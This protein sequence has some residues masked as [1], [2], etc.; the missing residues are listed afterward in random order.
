M[1]EPLPSPLD[2]LAPF[3]FQLAVWGCDTAGRVA[4]TTATISEHPQWRG[5]PN[6]YALW[7]GTADDLAGQF[8]VDEA[9]TANPVP[10]WWALAHAWNLPR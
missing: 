7:D 5:L 2:R 1:T 9:G 3:D 10:L 4:E 6:G 8:L